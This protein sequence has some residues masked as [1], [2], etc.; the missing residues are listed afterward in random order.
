MRSDRVML[1][2]RG[3]QKGGFSRAPRSQK[4][5]GRAT[6][7]QAAHQG[8]AGRRTD[9]DLLEEEENHLGQDVVGLFTVRM[10]ITVVCGAAQTGSVDAERRVQWNS[11]SKK[12][13][14]SDGTIKRPKVLGVT[15]RIRQAAPPCS[16]GCPGTFC[17]FRGQICYRAWGRRG[18]PQSS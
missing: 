9:S 6:V 2:C 13:G 3:A 7:A 12:I 4:E 16:R 8:Y 5:R 14:T 1:S 17:D 15:H 11:L 10:G 18:R